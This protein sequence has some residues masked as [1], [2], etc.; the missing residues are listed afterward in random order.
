MLCQVSQFG[1]P[2][3]DFRFKDGRPSW[4]HSNE[5]RSVMFTRMPTVLTALLVKRSA[6]FAGQAAMPPSRSPATPS[7][8]TAIGC[9]SLGICVEI[10][11]P[12]LSFLVKM[13][14]SPRGTFAARVRQRRHRLEVEPVVPVVCERRHALEVRI[15]A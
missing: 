11:L 5:A 12:V 4:T 6:C 2:L 10:V 14:V 9:H 7:F 1:L 13:T 8:Y 3:Y 15:G